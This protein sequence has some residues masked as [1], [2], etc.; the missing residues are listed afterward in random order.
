M[1]YH[2]GVSAV[3]VCGQSFAVLPDG[4]MFYLLSIILKPSQDVT[5]SVNS[6]NRMVIKNKRADESV[7]GN[8]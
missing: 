5:T 7:L 3:L 6:F 1:T 8:L 4:E 2:V